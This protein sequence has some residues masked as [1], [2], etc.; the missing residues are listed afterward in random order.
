M[1]YDPDAIGRE[2]INQFNPLFEAYG[3]QPD[4]EVFCRAIGRMIQ[5]IDDLAKDGG[6]RSADVINLITNPS[7]EIDTNGYSGLNAT[8]SRI[9]Y[10]TPY[11][12]FAI[13]STNTLGGVGGVGFTTANGT[14]NPCDRCQFST[15]FFYIYPSKTVQVR[16]SFLN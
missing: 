12:D 4:L 1:P 11:G 2:L 13:R 3:E 6:G 16:I 5:P 8:I 15:I 7:V 9:S 10:D 14:V